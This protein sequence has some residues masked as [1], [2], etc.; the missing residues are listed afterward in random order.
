MLNGDHPAHSAGH[1]RRCGRMANALTTTLESHE[2]GNEVRLIVLSSVILWCSAR[3]W[4]P[5][6]LAAVRAAPARLAA[7]CSAGVEAKRTRNGVTRRP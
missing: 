1:A 4:S 6:Q 5:V 2:A 7:C 3:P